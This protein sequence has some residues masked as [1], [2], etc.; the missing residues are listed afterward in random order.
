MD[1]ISGQSGAKV[2]LTD[3]VIE[4]D[5]TK[6]LAGE[7]VNFSVGGVAV[8][9]AITDSTGKASLPYGL[10]QKAGNY[11][12]TVQFAGDSNFAASNGNNNLTVTSTPVITPSVAIADIKA[13]MATSSKITKAKLIS[14]INAVLAQTGGS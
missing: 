3:E 9:T 7:S 14:Q 6:Y 2:T 12:I 8:G 4:T 10:T 5:N 11:P 1:P 13:I